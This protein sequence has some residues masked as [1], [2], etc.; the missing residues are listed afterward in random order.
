MF[1][2]RTM[3]I[4]EFAKPITS[5]ALN[6]SLA[7]TFGQKINLDAFTTEQLEDVR[8]K[9]RTKVFAMEQELPFD[10]LH[11]NS[12]Y[13]KNKLFI[14]TIHAALAEREENPASVVETKI[15]EG[16]ED[17]AELVM[18]AKDMVDRVTSWMEDTAEMQA[19][20][21]L[22]LAD[23]IRDEVGSEAS[24]SFV[25]TVKPALES[26]YTALEATRGSLTQGVG[27]LTGEEQAPAPDMGAEPAAPEGDVI[28]PA[29]EPTTDTED[30]FGAAAPAA[31]GEAEAG[32]EKRES[33]EISKKKLAELAQRSRRLAEVLSKKKS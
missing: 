29:M 31:G 27:Q 18:A 17:K 26:L 6:E 20:S 32:R 14:D 2:K 11:K 7:K 25:A 13:Q 24:E 21:M 5:K 12:S 23:A 22:Q 10:S 9:L 15:T 19:D 28:E 3:N 33:R 8:N 16:E 4:R 30:D 1:R